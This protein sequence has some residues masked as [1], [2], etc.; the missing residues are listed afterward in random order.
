MAT[1][2]VI[3]D[4]MSEQVLTWAAESY[5]PP[6]M[7]WQLDGKDEQQRW[8]CLATVRATLEATEPR[9]WP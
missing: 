9:E 6:L 2:C 1:V 8:N 7:F 4:A 5:M 3:P